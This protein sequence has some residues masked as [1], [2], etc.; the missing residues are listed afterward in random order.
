MP[1]KVESRERP[2]LLVNEAAHNRATDIAA[3]TR[4]RDFAQHMPQY[5]T[6]WYRCDAERQ[7]LGLVIEPREDGLPWYLGR[8]ILGAL[9][10]ANLLTPP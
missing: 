4:T 2:N 10:E 6:S 9:Q 5:K 7:I 3:H 8:A 1:A